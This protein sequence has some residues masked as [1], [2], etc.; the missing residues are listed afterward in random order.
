M[1][2]F[3]CSPE[4]VLRK[5]YTVIAERWGWSPDQIKSLPTDERR[6]YIKQI[7][8]MYEREQEASRK[9]NLKGRR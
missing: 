5:E 6:F 4:E 1:F 8:E 7:S 9:A 3:Q 2:F